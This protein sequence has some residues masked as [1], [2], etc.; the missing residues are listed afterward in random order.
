M[1]GHNNLTTINWSPS[2]RLPLKVDQLSRTWLTLWR[3][4][5]VGKIQNQS[6]GKKRNNFSSGYQLSKPHGRCLSKFHRRG[7]Q[8]CPAKGWI[9]TKCGQKGQIAA[10]CRTKTSSMSKNGSSG[11]KSRK[12]DLG[13]EKPLRPS[14]EE[15]LRLGYQ[16]RL[17]VCWTI[18]RLR[19]NHTFN[20]PNYDDDWLDIEGS[21][22]E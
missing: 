22:I 18:A 4:S 2:A 11:D 13:K 17:T 10:R 7:I 14:S 3:I 5:V 9:C 15:S 19:T 20:P 1:L 12:L 6:S 8:N 16:E 21:D